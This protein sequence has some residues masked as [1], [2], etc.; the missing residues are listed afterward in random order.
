[1]QE[2]HRFLWRALLDTIDIDLTG[3][4]VLDAGC[5]RGGF[6]RLLVDE[7]GDNG[8]RAWRPKAD[9][10]VAAAYDRGVP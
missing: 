7:C 8:F 6:L 1:M 3:S 4:R 10:G 2:E 5:N 9:S